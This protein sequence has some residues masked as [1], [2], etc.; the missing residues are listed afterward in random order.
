M[1]RP[2]RLRAIL[3]ATLLGA[4]LTACSN[5]STPA[6]TSNP[7]AS[8][9][10]STPAATS[11]DTLQQGVDDQL[12][13]TPADI[14]VKHGATLTVTNA[15]ASTTHTFTVTGMGIDITN[16]GGQS[17]QVKIDLPPGTYPFICT[18]HVSEGMK[19]TLTVT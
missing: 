6:A 15:S 17:Q 19:G 3:V 12:V 5:N 1:E 13:F 7:P 18:I 10:A 2:R 4:T 11:K 14:S 9:P 16:Q 8:T